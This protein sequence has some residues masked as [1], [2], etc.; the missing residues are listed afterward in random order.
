V[1]K[2]VDFIEQA[3]NLSYSAMA[4]TFDQSK[5]EIA[6]CWLF[7]SPDV[8]RAQKCGL[9]ITVIYHTL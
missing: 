1:C 2:F 7:I 8:F 3:Y 9:L 4:Y 6:L 5:D